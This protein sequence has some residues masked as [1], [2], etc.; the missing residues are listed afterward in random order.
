MLVPS[1]LYFNVLA[2][3]AVPGPRGHQFIAQTRPHAQSA[4]AQREA[5]REQ[6]SNGILKQG[7]GPARTWPALARQPA[8]NRF[9]RRPIEPGCAPS[10][11]GVCVI[12][13]LPS[14]AFP[15]RSHRHSR[16]PSSRVIR[17]AGNA[18]GGLGWL[19][20]RFGLRRG[21][22]ECVWFAE[23]L[24]RRDLPGTQRPWPLRFFKSVAGRSGR[25]AAAI[26]PRP[27]SCRRGKRSPACRAACGS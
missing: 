5:N 9:G 15:A 2:G 23:P 11:S 7:V 12:A 10:P 22:A 25:R 26:S 3:V 27:S 6:G 21:L 14:P 1:S 4:Q 18:P 13:R 24:A 20:R 16:D 19:L 8:W 17:P